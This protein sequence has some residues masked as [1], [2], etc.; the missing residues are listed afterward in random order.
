LEELAYKTLRSLLTKRI[1]TTGEERPF[2]NGVFW[3][4]ENYVL[5][6]NS[7]VAKHGL[8]PKWGLRGVRRRVADLVLCN[9]A[10]PEIVPYNKSAQSE[11]PLLQDVFSQAILAIECKNLNL[12]YRWGYPSHIRAFDDD[13]MSRFIWAGSERPNNIANV[14]GFDA[15]WE[16]Y[17][18]WQN[19]FPRAVKVLL[20]PNFIWLDKARPSPRTRGT[21]ADWLQKASDLLGANSDPRLIANA[22]WKLEYD[23]MPPSF[24]VRDQIEWRIR[25][26]KLN[27]FELG[28]QPKPNR[29]VPYKVKR[30]LASLLEPCV[31]K[32]VPKRRVGRA[33]R[34]KDT[35]A[36]QLGAT[37][38]KF[39][40]TV[41][42][43]RLKYLAK[44]GYE[45]PSAR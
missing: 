6:W 36:K 29:W 20:M 11:T 27:V 2:F 17:A 10:L 38:S 13:I 30:R 5:F 31:R 39:D 42:E 24:S 4:A 37:R 3:Q 35:R 25:R 16:Q 14:L 8:Y 21:P 7:Q 40:A 45:P 1:E 33:I 28:Y 18:G 26:L 23:L 9:T 44:A 15:D 34:T 19:L 32:L 41:L 43:K 22:A 12:D